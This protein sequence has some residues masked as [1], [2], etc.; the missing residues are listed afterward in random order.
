M[1]MHMSVNSQTKSFNFCGTRGT[2][3]QFPQLVTRN[4]FDLR[5]PTIF[6]KMQHIQFCPP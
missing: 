3:I 5:K 2:A 4:D 1:S 6:I